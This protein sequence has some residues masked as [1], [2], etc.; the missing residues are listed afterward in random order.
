MQHQDAGARE[1]LLTTAKLQ[2][3]LITTNGLS[4]KCPWSEQEGRL[5]DAWSVQGSWGADP[6]FSHP[7]ASSYNRV[8]TLCKVRWNQSG[9]L[10]AVLVWRG[11]LGKSMRCQHPW[12]DCWEQ[13]SWEMVAAG[14]N[15]SY[16]PGISKSNAL[17]RCTVRLYSSAQGEQNR[18]CHPARGC[19]ASPLDRETK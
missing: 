4:L 16:L 2:S 1:D 17:T 5:S 7:S 14:V 19:S 6:T 8:E 11:M 13:R 3:K 12:G 15:L 9:V 10:D 18:G